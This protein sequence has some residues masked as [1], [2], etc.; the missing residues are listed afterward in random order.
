MVTLPPE[1][2][3][4]RYIALYDA[5]ISRDKHLEALGDTLTEPSRRAQ[6]FARAYEDQASPEDY[7]QYLEI[8]ER[9]LKE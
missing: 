3:A 7:A 9:L 4:R 6:E 8:L 5:D 2:A 1:D